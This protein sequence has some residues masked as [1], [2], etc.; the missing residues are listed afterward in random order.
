MTFCQVVLLIAI[1][2]YFLQAVQWLAVFLCNI[3]ANGLIF[4][5]FC[6][7]TGETEPYERVKMREELKSFEKLVMKEDTGC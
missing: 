2:Y 1:S 4:D 7:Q 5:I 3:L 6:E